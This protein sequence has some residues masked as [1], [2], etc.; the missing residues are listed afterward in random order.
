VLTK[1]LSL[2]TQPVGGTGRAQR[3]EWEDEEARCHD[4]FLTTR[5]AIG[6]RDSS[7]RKA[8][9]ARLNEGDESAHR[10]ESVRCAGDCVGLSPW[11]HLTLLGRPDRD[12][13][14]R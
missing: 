7:K 5:G 10:S 14:E 13:R 6:F 11:T 2:T 4:G 8:D 12:R 1:E 9:N 3:E